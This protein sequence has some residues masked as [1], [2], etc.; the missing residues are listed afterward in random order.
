MSAVG[1]LNAWPAYLVLAFEGG[2]LGAALSGF[3]GMLALNR[4]PTYYHPVFNAPSLPSPARTASSCWWKPATGTL[5]RANALLLLG[6][7]ARQVADVPYSAV[8]AAGHRRSWSSSSSPAAPRP[9]ARFI[10]SSRA[11]KI[12]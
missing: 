3:F 2:I 8:A 12:Y 9:P 4:L 10:A 5:I 7:G 6:L 1:R 11:H